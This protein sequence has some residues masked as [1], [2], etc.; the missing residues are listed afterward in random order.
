LLITGDPEH[1][2]V[3]TP[4]LAEKFVRQWRKGKL[5]HVPRAGHNIHRDQYVFVM[6]AISSF[7]NSLGKWSPRG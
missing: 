4:A 3:I 6:Q 5:V 7:L 2:A 1:G